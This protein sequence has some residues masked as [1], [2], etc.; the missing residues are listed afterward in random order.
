MRCSNKIMNP[1]SELD[2]IISAA[3]KLYKE[4]LEYLGESV[5]NSVAEIENDP[6]LIT[7]KGD[8]ATEAFVPLRLK[9]LYQDRTTKDLIEGLKHEL[10]Q[11]LTEY[12]IEHSQRIKLERQTELERIEK[13]E[14]QEETGI[15]K[16]SIKELETNLENLRVKY[17]SGMK[18][19]LNENN[20]F[21]A[22]GFKNKQVIEELELVLKGK[23]LEIEKVSCEK[24]R[25]EK[26]F[27]E[28]W[29]ESER[30]KA[31]LAGMEKEFFEVTERVKESNRE[32]EYL[33]RELCKVSEEK[34][35]LEESTSYFKRSITSEKEK[36]LNDFKD[37]V[38]EVRRRFSSKLIQIKEDLLKKTSEIQNYKEVMA[39]LENTLNDSQKH[40]YYEKSELMNLLENNKAEFKETVTNLL[41]KRDFDSKKHEEEI[42]DLKSYYKVVMKTQLDEFESRAAEFFQRE[43]EKDEQ[44]SRLLKEI[45][46]DYIEKS[47]HKVILTEHSEQ[48]KSSYLKQLAVIEN[49]INSKWEKELKILMIEKKN[50]IESVKIQVEMLENQ[51]EN[52]GKKVVHLQGLLQECKEKIEEFKEANNELCGKLENFQEMENEFLEQLGVVNKVTGQLKA[53]IS[54]L[55]MEKMEVEGKNGELE[56]RA[57]ELLKGTSEMEKE[58]Q[59]EKKYWQGENGKL[60]EE[61]KMLYAEIER[62]KVELEKSVENGKILQKKNQETS[63][64]GKENEEKLRRETQVEKEKNRENMQKVLEDYEYFKMQLEIANKKNGKCIQENSYL[65]SQIEYF[66]EELE[67]SLAKCEALKNSNLELSGHISEHEKAIKLLQDKLKNL[68]QSH[69]KTIETLKSS[70]QEQIHSTSQSIQNL[71]KNCIEEI[72]LF[73]KYFN[74]KTQE[75]SNFTSKTFLNAKIKANNDQTH[76]KMSLSDSQID[77]KRYKDLLIQFEQQHY[78]DTLLME[79]L[80]YEINEKCE[81]LKKSQDLSEKFLEKCQFLEKNQSDLSVL[82][83]LKDAEIAKLREEYYKNLTDSEVLYKDSM[84]L[85][86]FYKKH[87]K[88]L[89]ARVNYLEESQQHEYDELYNGIFLLKSQFKEEIEEVYEKHKEVLHYKDCMLGTKEKTEEYY[90]E[91]CTTMEKDSKRSEIKLLKKIDEI[92]NELKDAKIKLKFAEKELSLK[93]SDDLQR[94]SYELTS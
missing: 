7:L 43:K 40:F 31:K 22:E 93:K 84:G 76:L 56:R 57:F 39:G 91:V 44:Y 8:S 14:A 68:R 33:N 85:D 35:E 89:L 73:K 74:G 92:E 55:Q 37:E 19:K 25:L 3:Q 94:R 88:E 75:I 20:E 90:K 71:K 13:K 30:V 36:E 18:N 9:E 53:Q 26:E 32:I 83:K 87:L 79:K 86:E 51:K 46:E 29:K 1:D 77:S 81:S 15:L 5:R 34:L 62:T 12:Q 69:S 45:S 78:E 58:T 16:L 17:E 6:L 2:S 59:K 23:N 80:T 38:K 70:F 61:I 49:E 48:L 63:K 82:V 52:E 10:S 11:A 64:V 42:E 72:I 50:Q 66:K 27:N 41:K 54:E 47:T 21:K 67:A 24:E 60:I 4:K 28:I 65:S